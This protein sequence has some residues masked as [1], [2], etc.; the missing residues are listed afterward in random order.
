MKGL[1]YSFLTKENLH[2]IKKMYCFFKLISYYKYETKYRTLI[3][4]SLTFYRTQ[5]I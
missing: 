4:K 3:N 2:I 5:Y 1:P